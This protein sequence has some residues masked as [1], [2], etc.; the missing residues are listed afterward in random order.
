MIRNAAWVVAVLLLDLRVGQAQDTARPLFAQ[1]ATLELR[2][3]A[4]FKRLAQDTDDRDE[5]DGVVRYRD[6]ATGQEIAL[7]AEIR[8]RGKSRLK[9][10]D[11][12]PLRIDFD[13]DALDGTV[14]AGQNHL[15]LATLCKRRDSSREDLIE[16]YEIYKAFNALTDYSFRVRW[17]AVTY[18]D[19]ED[20]DAEQFTEPA[21]FVEEDWEV[22]ERNGLKALDVPRVELA[23]LDKRAVA[24]SSLF[25]FMIANVDWA[26]TQPAPD[27]KDCCHNGKPIGSAGRG[28]I[29]LPYDF[30]QSGLVSAAYARPML[31]LRSVRERR[32]RGYCVAN[33]E[34]GWAVQRFDERRTAIERIFDAE[35][36]DERTR[37]RTLDYIAKFYDII[38]DADARQRQIV[39]RCRGPD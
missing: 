4:P 32:Y 22:A 19:T 10:C 25:Q 37:G 5:L 38:D 34:V 8:V 27:E 17:L 2:V 1:D 11:F 35:T 20:R 28:V 36:I 12:P 24:L 33:S 9:L 7:E 14:F 23:D 30:D 16:E 21:F 6:S 26:A 18:A 13:R 29:V 3:E 15:K 31:D 39:A